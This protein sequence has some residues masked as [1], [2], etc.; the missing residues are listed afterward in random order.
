[1]NTVIDILARWWLRSGRYRWSKMRRWLFERHYLKEPLPEA[2][3]LKD[4]EVCLKQITWKIEG[5]LHLYDSISY[6]QTTWVKKKDDCDGFASLAAELLYRLN[7]N[8]RPVLITTVVRPIAKSHTV[9]AF[10]NLRGNLWYFDNARL[11]REKYKTYDEIAFKVSQR[12]KSLICWDVRNHYT[13]DLIEF[14]QSWPE[15]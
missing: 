14:H 5:L 7:S 2:D 8:Y 3:S 12:G 6:P 9:C 1:M 10:N 11:K 4:I 13:F 15:S